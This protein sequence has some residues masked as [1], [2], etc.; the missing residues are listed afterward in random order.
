LRCNKHPMVSDTNYLFSS[1][2]GGTV[3]QAGFGQEV[4]LW[5]SSSG[6]CQSHAG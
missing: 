4:L 6:V 5:L 1:C 2:F 3:V